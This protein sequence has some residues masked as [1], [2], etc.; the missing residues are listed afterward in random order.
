MGSRSSSSSVREQ[1]VPQAPGS[2]TMT[3][4]VAK[5]NSTGQNRSSQQAGPSPVE[6]S[7]SGGVGGWVSGFTEA[8]ANVSSRVV[9][10]RA[11]EQVSNRSSIQS[12]QDH[13]SDAEHSYPG[14]RNSYQQEAGINP[15]APLWVS[16][17]AHGTGSEH[18]SQRPLPSGSKHS[19][20]GSGKNSQHGKN[21]Q[22]QQPHRGLLQS[23]TN[24][25]RSGVGGSNL[26]KSGSGIH[27]A[28]Q[29]PDEES[30]FVPGGFVHR[31]AEKMR[32][33]GRSLKIF[34]PQNPLRLWLASILKSKYA[35]CI[36]DVGMKVLPRIF[37]RKYTDPII[38][39]IILT[40]WVFFVITPTTKEAKNIF[41]SY[42]TH[43]GLLAIN[44]LYTLEI[45]SK[46]IVYGLFFDR[47]GFQ[48]RNRTPKSIQRFIDSFSSSSSRLPGHPKH[49]LALSHVNSN[50]SRTSITE[51]HPP[52]IPTNTSAAPVAG[53]SPASIAGSEASPAHAPFFTS[54]YNRLD[55]IV[56]ICYWIDFTFMIVGIQEIYIFKAMSTLRPLRLLSLTEGTSTIIDS[57]S[58]SA[59]LLLTILG[60]I[61]FFF[62]I[63]S[64][65]GLLVFQGALSRRCALPEPD[66]P[67]NW[68]PVSPEV[69]CGGYY[70]NGTILGIINYKG[71]GDGDD[72]SPR[73][74][75]MICPE[76]QVC[77]QFPDYNPSRNLIS[78]DNFFFSLLTVFTVS[79]ME[80]WTDVEYW[81]M[82]GDSRWAA[83]FFCIAIFLMSFLMIP[84]FI[85]GITYSFGAVRAEKRHSAFSNKPR[86]KRIL[87]ETEEGWQFQDQVLQVRSPTRQWLIRLV[88]DPWF[89]TFGAFMVF[90]NLIAMC[91]RRYDNSPAELKRIDYAEVAFTLYFLLEICVR[92]AG[93]STWIQFWKRK[94]NVF[95]LFLAITTTVILLPQIHHWEWFR[96]L[97]VF[98]VLRS[99]RM[100]PAI[101]GVRDLM[102]SV[103]GSATGMMNLLL[104]TFMF[105]LV[106]APIP[107]VLFGHDMSSE[108][109]QPVNFD[110]LGQSFIS[111]FIILTGENWVNVMYEGLDAHPEKWKQAYGVIFFVVYYCASHYVLLNLFIAIILEHFEM[112]DDEKYKTQLE[113]YFQRHQRSKVNKTQGVLK[114][115]NPYAYLPAR[116]QTL[117]VDGLSP[118]QT[119]VVRKNV[120][121]QFL[122]GDLAPETSAIMES[123]S[124]FIVWL[125]RARDYWFP[126]L[127]QIQAAERAKALPKPVKPEN[128]INAGVS[129]F[130]KTQDEIDA[131]LERLD[132]GL[133]KITWDMEQSDEQQTGTRLAP[134]DYRNSLK[135]KAAKDDDQTH[136]REFLEAHPMYDRSL[137]LLPSNN[138]FRQWCKQVVGPRTG[139]QLVTMNRF[140]WFIF[141][142]IL[143]SIAIVI[144]DDPVDRMAAMMTGD[145]R[146][147]DILHDIDHVVTVIFVAEQGLRILADGFLFTPTA[148][149]RD[150]WN[151]LDFFIVLMSCVMSFAEI[152]HLYS[153]SRAI[154]ALSCLRVLRI[155]RYFDGVSAMF[156]AIAK[157]L[158][159]MIIAM[160][161]TALLFWPFAIYGVNIYAGYFYLCN[162]HTVLTKN[163]CMGEFMNE[164]S[165]DENGD[166]LIPRIWSNPY[167]Y[168]FDTVQEAVLTLF[169]MASQE[170]WVLVMQ[171]G[172]AVPDHLGDQ[173][174]IQANEPNRFN[175]FY[176]LVFMLL[177]SIVFVQIFIGVILE[178]FK[179]WNG[180]S[181]L[182]VE[183][184]RWIDLRRQL[185]LIKPTATPARPENKFRAFCY[186]MVIKKKG[187]LW[188]IMTVILVMNVLL[189]A[190]QHYG[191]PGLL[192]DIQVYSIEIIIKMSGYG[193]HKWRLSRWNLY[194]MVITT[195][196]L[197]TL[198]PRFIRHELWTLRL[199]K[200]LLITISFRLAQRID[201]LQVLFRALAIALASILNITAV[202]MVVFTV[203]A[204]M[205]RE[206]FG[207]TR[208]GPSTT[209]L[210]NF[211]TF[212]NTMLMLIRM[213][214]G[215]NWDFVMHDMMVEAPECTPN[216]RTYLDSDCGSRPW[217][218]FMFLSFY[219]ICTYIL[220]NM[221]IAVIISNF[222]FAYQQDSLTTLITREDLRNFK[223]TWA[224]FD[225]RGTGYIDPKYLSKF[226]RSV[227]GRLCTRVYANPEISIP[228]LCKTYAHPTGGPATDR[229]VSTTTD[230]A[231]NSSSSPPSPSLHGA[232]GI[233]SVMG[234]S[235][236]SNRKN[237]RLSASP[238]LSGTQSKDGSNTSPRAV[239]ITISG[240]G[241][242]L[243][244][245]E[246]YQALLDSQQLDMQGL[247]QTLAK[248][249]YK[250]VYRRRQKYNLVYKEAIATATTRGISFY[251]I[252]DILSFTLVD[253]EQAL[254][255]DEFLRRNERVRELRSAVARETIHNLLLTIIARRN[256]LKQ[257]RTKQNSRS[258]PEVPRIVIDNSIGNEGNSGPETSPMLTSSPGGIGGL[259][260]GRSPLLD[261]SKGHSYHSDD[262][263]S[264]MNYSTNTMLSISSNDSNGWESY[265]RDSF[266]R[267]SGQTDS[268]DFALDQRGSVGAGSPTG[269]AVEGSVWFN[270][271]QDQIRE[272]DEVLQAQLRPSSY[273]SQR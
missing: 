256:F 41:G 56:V 13:Q 206:L 272:Q 238:S 125:E 113:M 108:S 261:F 40:Q 175:S 26:G 144:A 149:L 207:M 165:G 43:Y 255:M 170:G 88:N 214:T 200:F 241:E 90:L 210:A 65:I 230:A 21:G 237:N 146:R 129:G 101:P 115:L 91:F 39:V 79:S 228:H 6:H 14:N 29:P 71:Q 50:H 51:K 212:G 58:I 38:L 267:Q 248:I 193:F 247:Q 199:E 133:E 153:V 163:E 32:L 24:Q 259:G 215:E 74:S 188:R 217:A 123:K 135:D 246:K 30:V 233:R 176:F 177:G 76:P 109:D 271:L 54:Y 87:L 190:S 139:R 218:Y 48:W 99:Y 126:T 22:Q 37:G 19:S 186:D 172:R 112:D 262:D 141:A 152:D 118:D 243:S 46:V 179:T 15:D 187:I 257:R 174:F 197:F 27:D 180:I 103:I 106:C 158:P 181:L 264:P 130:G 192:T 45:M 136:T 25:S 160:V 263:V 273:S 236:I 143:L 107:M 82:D 67:Q 95:D 86:S 147:Q 97:T 270:M 216:R 100:I 157:A 235:G 229:R 128:Q 265:D 223:M 10:T 127:A 138:R 134:E 182:T 102:R 251:T 164:P 52:H 116:P 202:F 178:T 225:P 66:N 250:E 191:Q 203:Y 20:G 5:N 92:I 132:A 244:E 124:K 23:A 240:A 253:I 189:I 162:D 239:P 28:Q 183:Q 252:L 81:V 121:R 184:R 219:I 140:N 110:D 242:G 161:L 3:S 213:T 8:M 33:E 2:P 154:R 84:L 83:I 78:F 80:G 35:I 167:E 55:G 68:I 209:G 77:M 220:L 105:L 111:L 94:S 131:N 120:F 7:A 42:W 34:S 31:G 254:G 70:S 49:S 148:Y 194:D 232:S 222:S 93:H 16:P 150:L 196:A 201:S 155:V 9:N 159:R 47:N 221:F 59:P 168:S 96:Y 249:D 171:S 63:L 72:S 60:F 61:F 266:N 85:A 53:T 98:Q 205:F 114:Y 62:L 57:L 151:F 269:F 122:E 204:I 11:Q 36:A 226:L 4:M 268:S 245:N 166:I 44:I 17:P 169:E 145:T 156:R 119:V 69:L 224:K 104:I 234:L 75:G 117:S 208:L 18:G 64:L 198:I 1:S 211:E 258:R 12:L 142:C 260:G 73:T 231:G 185:R 227:D 137:F 89:P 173:P 195:L